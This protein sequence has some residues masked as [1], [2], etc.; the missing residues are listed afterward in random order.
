MW[1]LKYKECIDCGSDEWKHIAR[2]LCVRCYNRQSELKHR[3]HFIERG[4]ASNKLTKAYLLDEYIMKKKSL[5]DIAIECACTRQYVYKRLVQY[6]IPLRDK[7]SALKIA[8][9][10]GKKS[11][12]VFGTHGEKSY[13]VTPQK[14]EY[15]ERFFTS[16]SPEMA[17]VLGVIYTDG[18]LEAGPIKDPTRKTTARIARLFV[19]QKEPELLNK[20]LALMDCNAKLTFRERRKYRD[21]VAGELYSFGI[22]SNKLYDDLISL[23]LT[24]KKSLI[25]EF[26][27]VPPEYMRHFIRGCWDGDGSVYISGGKL[28]TK[29]DTGSLDFIERLVQELY[30]V[31]VYGQK[32]KG[33]PLGKYPLAIHRHKKARAYYTSISLRKSLEN[34]FHYFYDGVDE[35]IYLKRKY[36]TFLQGLAP[37]F[38]ASEKTSPKSTNKELSEEE[39][40]V[41]AI[42]KL[43][44]KPYKGIHTV[45][46]GFNDAW[47][48]HFGTDP[49]EG[50][51]KLA[52]QGKTEILPAK[53][54]AIIYLP[55]EGPGPKN[56]L[57]I[58]LE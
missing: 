26:P 8:L 42:K 9:D 16:W 31:G 36:E 47:R 27:K 4:I 1:S 7:T 19:A 24:P 55:G 53:G 41:R 52:Q 25:I 13:T 18:T 51:Q 6:D 20:I 56:V 57:D 11:Y 34:L 10:R 49:V 21:T 45:Y 15:D 58:I 44:K 17:Y 46:S 29:F 54:G 30:E 12:E 3:G 40:T 28:R 39:F 23:G 5:S 37:M 50:V 22:T 32:L 43:R 33:H 35:S 14:I 2:G 38:A 48:D